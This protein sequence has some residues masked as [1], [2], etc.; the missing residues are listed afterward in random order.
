VRSRRSTANRVLTILKAALNYAYHEGHA[1]SDE[2]W[3][4][5]KPFRE[6]D[7]AI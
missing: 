6:V 2:A 1:V 7:T 5:V 4:K 3:R